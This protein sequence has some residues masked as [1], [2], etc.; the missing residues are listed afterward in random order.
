MK[1]STSAV[2]GISRILFGTGVFCWFYYFFAVITEPGTAELSPLVPALC[3]AASYCAGTI[4]S[5]RGMKI[6][7]FILIQLVLCA[8][9]IAVMQLLLKTGPD[10]FNFRLVTSI[11]LAVAIAACARAAASELRP[12][13][14]AHRFDAGLILCAVLILADHYLQA[15]YGRTALAVLAAAMIFLLLSLAMIRSDKDAAIGSA[16]G[17]ILPVILIVLIALIAGACAALGTGAAQSA[18][19]ALVSAVRGLLGMITSAAAFLWSRWEAFCSWL[20]SKF[21]PGE[22]VP[23]NTFEPDQQ[24]D[25]PEPAEL[26]HTSVIVLYALTVL[27]A[28]AIIAAFV[29]AIRKSRLRRIN[30]GRFNNRVAVRQVASGGFAEYLSALA[31]RLRYRMDCIRYRN[32]PAGLL[33]WC[34]DHVPGSEKK[35]PQESGPGFVLRLAEGQPEESSDALRKLAELLEKAFYSPSSAVADAS[36]CAAVRR[37]RFRRSGDAETAEAP[38]A[39]GN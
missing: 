2:C 35:R 12:E 21:E 29:Y 36:L 32:T 28:V 17:R 33:A 14:L 18:A 16:A 15:A 19:G 20:A 31:A 30:T 10:A 23:V 1:R 26:S 27:L 4:A 34:E 25:V 5:R 3:L 24:S 39:A 6:L 11:A 8:A 7:H 9:G 37:C 13:A 22:A 38:A